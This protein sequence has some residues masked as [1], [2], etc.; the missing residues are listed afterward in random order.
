MRLYRLL[1]VCGLGCALQACAAG[2]VTPI[3]LTEAGAV[4]AFKPIPNSSR[5][6]CEMQKAVAEHNSVL[7][8]IKSKKDVVYK[9]PC[10]VDKGGP[11][12]KVAANG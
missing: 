2:N 3:A 6:P 8:T 9:A 4:R 12:Q 1:T 10:D 11:A 7:E 5:A